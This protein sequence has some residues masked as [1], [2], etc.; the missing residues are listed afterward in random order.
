MPMRKIISILITAFI[1]VLGIL[2]IFSIGTKYHYFIGALT[3]F[4]AALNIFIMKQ[5]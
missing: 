3:V 5:A 1:F 4:L 2:L